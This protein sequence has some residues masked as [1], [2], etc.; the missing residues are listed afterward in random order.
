MIA[1]RKRHEATFKS[2]VALEALKGNKTIQE[3]ASEYEVHPGQISDWKR[4]L[5]EGLL[6]IFDQKQKGG[7]GGSE[8]FEK[9]RGELHAKI[10]ELTVKLDFVVK[11]S[12]QLGL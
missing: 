9:E 3:I 10:G 2:R 7:R 4:I 1:K 8:D 6:G 11:K 5:A 12:R